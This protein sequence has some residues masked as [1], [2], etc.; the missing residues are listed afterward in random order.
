M[1]EGIKALLWN[2]LKAKKVSLAMIYD[3]SGSILWYR[4]RKINGRSIHDGEGF[5][6][7]FI[8]QTLTDQVN[9]IKEENVLINVSAG[10]LSESAVNLHV[11]SLIILPIG[12]PFFL[13]IDSGVKESFNNND[14]EAF[15]LIGKMLAESIHQIKKSTVDVGGISGSSPAITQIKELILKYSLE[16]D[17]IILLGETGV[18]K[19]HIAALIHQCS[20]RK[21]RFIVADTTTI[22]ENLFESEI[23]GHRKG[24]FT[25]AIADKKGLI[26]EAHQGTLFFDEIAEVPISFQSKLLRFIETRRYRVLGETCEH[27]ADVR[28]VAATNIDLQKAIDN[29]QFREDLYFRLSVL[30]IY[31]PPLRQRTQ[32]IEALTLERRHYLKGKEIGSGFWQIMHQYQWP[33]NIRELITVLKRAGILCNSPITGSELQTIIDQERNTV[34]I[35][36]NTAPLPPDQAPVQTAWQAI[37]KGMTFWEAVKEPFLNRDLNRAQVKM[38]ISQALDQTNGRY[39]DTLPIFN[40]KAGEY[41][42]FMKFLHK[43]KLQS[44]TDT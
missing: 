30:K 11:K 21:G 9:V 17:P 35:Q 38:I 24:S 36:K 20:G 29:T 28:I 12:D 1:I 15:K 4:G 8:R 16:E 6:K 44:S 32:D 33:G 43:N 7:S 13:Y 22:N 26:D 25:G 3:K 31:I 37:K 23:F 14:Y 34:P 41:K 2:Q 40:I 19:S 5:S 10:M 27:E 39:I 18:G 42:R